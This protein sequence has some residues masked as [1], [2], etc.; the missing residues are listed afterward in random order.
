MLV[1]GEHRIHL[2]CGEERWDNHQEEGAGREEA[3]L[4][5]RGVK[6]AWEEEVVGM[7]RSQSAVHCDFEGVEDHQA[8]QEELGVD[9]RRGIQVGH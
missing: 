7:S 1:D 4:I 5:G 8:F 9:R 3:G 6:M 2:A